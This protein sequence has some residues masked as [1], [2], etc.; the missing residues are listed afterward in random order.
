MAICFCGVIVRAKK[1]PELRA[2]IIAALWLGLLSA[3][4]SAQSNPGYVWINNASY[5][6]TNLEPGDTAEITVWTQA[7]ATITMSN[8]GGKQVAIGNSGSTGLA[9]FNFT[10]TASTVGSYVEIWYEN[11]HEMDEL[12]YLR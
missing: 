3:S 9:Y 4:A 10:Q 8:N 5:P 11:G 7:N 12:L 1:L 2:L 6:G